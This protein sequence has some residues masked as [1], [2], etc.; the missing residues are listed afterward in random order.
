[1]SRQVNELIDELVDELVVT[2]TAATNVGQVWRVWL[3]RRCDGT[4]QATEQTT[5][6]LVYLF[7]RL[8]VYSSTCLLVYSFTRLLVYSFTHQLSINYFWKCNLIPIKTLFL[9]Y[10]T[11][12]NC[13]GTIFNTMLH[14]LNYLCAVKIM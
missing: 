1:M 5:C 14:I 11:I 6:L 2:Q 8:L 3:V 12:F 7:T 13:V 9:M 10:E 4:P